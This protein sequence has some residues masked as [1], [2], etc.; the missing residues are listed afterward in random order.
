[1]FDYSDIDLYGE[2][3]LADK[4][5]LTKLAE[6][7]KDYERLFEKYEFGEAS[8]ILYNFIWEEFC[9]WYIEIAKISLNGGDLAA[10]KTTQSVLIYVLD[11]SLKMLHPF[12]PFVT[13]EIWQHIPHKGDSIVTSEFVKLNEDLVF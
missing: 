3:T 7:S 9:S 1:G 6:T 13:E 11:A 4:Y 12:M 10:K 2:K 5:I 8:R